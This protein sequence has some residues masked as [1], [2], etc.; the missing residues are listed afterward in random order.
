MTIKCSL[1]E[2]TT[3]NRAV[4][5]LGEGERGEVRTTPRLRWVNFDDHRLCAGKRVYDFG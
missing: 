3:D 4:I 2:I 5:C 1:I